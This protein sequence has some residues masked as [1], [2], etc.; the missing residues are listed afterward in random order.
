MSDQENYARLH[1]YSPRRG[2]VVQ[3]HSFQ[4]QVYMGG[5]RP[6]W[7]RVSSELAELLR[8]QLQQHDNPDSKPLFQIV[9]GEEKVL[10]EAQEQQEFL[11]SVGAAARTQLAP[12]DVAPP[13]TVDIRPAAQ[14]IAPAVVT[15][16]P[17]VTEA[18]VGRAAALPPPREQL[19]TA[20][21]SGAVTSAEVMAG[22]KGAARPNVRGQDKPGE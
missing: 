20:N 21:E 14:Q 1:P 6:N 19:R 12:R 11:A 13:P 17:E 4:S 8:P 15:A 16:A 2:Y 22:R 18:P 9:S 10:I 5:P 3:K 7:Y